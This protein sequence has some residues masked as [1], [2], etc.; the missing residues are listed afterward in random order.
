MISKAINQILKVV[1]FEDDKFQLRAVKDVLRDIPE[2][3]IVGIYDTIP[4]ALVKCQELRPDLIIADADIRG[5][6]AIGPQFVKSVRKILPL[7]KV[8]GLTA[9]DDCLT[10]LIQAGCK[11]A[12]L[13]KF[14]HDEE[15]ARKF[16]RATLLEPIIVP[17]QDLP[18]KLESEEDL[19]L[20][21]ISNGRTEKEIMEKL[22][23]TRRQVTRV[24]DNLNHKFGVNS[25]KETQLVAHA[26]QI[27]YLR[28]DED[29]S[30]Y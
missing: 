4:E 3:N 23:K 29:L 6:K 19:V 2:I 5:N 22:G 15:S 9:Y 26:Y 13:K 30:E 21:M 11:E 10:P 8:L 17:P 20:R 7:V 14:F 28:S 25:G 1:I 16:I 12:V 18:P 27:G 24:K